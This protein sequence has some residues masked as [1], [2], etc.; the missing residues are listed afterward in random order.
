M[1]VVMMVGEEG[2]CTGAKCPS[3]CGSEVSGERSVLVAAG[4][5]CPRSE[6]SGSEVSGA[7]CPGAKCPRAKCPV[8]VLNTRAMCVKN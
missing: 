2:G 8:S 1:V 4:S 5:K 7:K 6:V 3:R